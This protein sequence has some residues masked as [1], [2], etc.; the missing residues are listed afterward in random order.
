MTETT[1]MMNEQQKQ[2]LLAEFQQLV[3]KFKQLKKNL[4]HLDEKLQ[5]LK[6]TY[7]ALEELEKQPEEV[8]LYAPVAQGLFVKARLEN[9]K[10]VL[11]NVGANIAVEKSSAEAQTLIENQHTELKEVR[12]AMVQQIQQIQQRLEQIKQLVE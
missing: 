8:P 11:V 9:A 12:D 3:P 10:R 4:E 6:V 7:A 1:T 5:E 2:E